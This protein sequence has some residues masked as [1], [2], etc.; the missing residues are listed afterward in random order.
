MIA[1]V[2]WKHRVCCFLTKYPNQF[3]YKFL[4]ISHSVHRELLQYFQIL[5]DMIRIIVMH[6]N[7]RVSLLISIS[8]IWKAEFKFEK[9]CHDNRIGMNNNF[10][11][12]WTLTFVVCCRWSS[13]RLDHENK[14]NRHKKFPFFG[15]NSLEQSSP[16]TAWLFSDL[17]K[18]SK[19]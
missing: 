3:A 8:C 9:S 14:N 6:V 11:C 2:P 15:T 19:D 5:R 4:F 17:W 10:F 1:S 16:S 18:F 12:G 13:R 7:Q